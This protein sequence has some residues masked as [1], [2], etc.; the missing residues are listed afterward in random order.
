MPSTPDL[1]RRPCLTKPTKSRRSW[2]Q[3]KERR[4]RSH[5]TGVIALY[6][7]ERSPLRMPRASGPKCSWATACAQPESRTNTTALPERNSHQYQRGTSFNLNEGT[8]LSGVV[9]T[10]SDADGNTATG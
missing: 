4:I 7:E 10:F 2:V 9:A 8:T 6:A 1:Q 3:P 5:F